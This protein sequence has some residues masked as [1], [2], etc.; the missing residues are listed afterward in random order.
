MQ[1][2]NSN[3]CFSGKHFSRTRLR[4]YSLLPRG[5]QS[6]ILAI[7]RGL[8]RE[9]T[10]Q[11]FILLAQIIVEVPLPGLGQGNL[12]ARSGNSLS[13]RGNIVNS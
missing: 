8:R 9:V 4:T 1:G 3:R 7:D 5:L 6:E 11:R 2:A 12:R 13:S 10:A